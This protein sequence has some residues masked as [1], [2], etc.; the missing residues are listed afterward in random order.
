M[1]GHSVAGF[2]GQKKPIFHKKAKVSKKV[3]LRLTCGECHRTWM[4]CIG[5]TKSFVSV[6]CACSPLHMHMERFAQ[7][8]WFATDL[9]LSSWPLDCATLNAD[10]R[11]VWRSQEGRDGK[12]LSIIL[13]NSET[14]VR[15]GRFRLFTSLQQR[16]SHA[17]STKR[18]VDDSLC[19]FR[20]HASMPTRPARAVP[21]STS[22]SAALHLC[23]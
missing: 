7:F 21:L 19:P 14:R 5:R 22:S 12:L 8:C 2:G 10:S 23:A 18:T 15:V 3:S 1:M 4:R 17:R 13:Q 16:P 11:R 9:L 6:P 20:F